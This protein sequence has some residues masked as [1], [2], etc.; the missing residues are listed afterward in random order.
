MPTKFHP[1]THLHPAVPAMRI[2]LIVFVLIIGQALA[3]APGVLAVDPDSPYNPLGIKADS[4]NA[5]APLQALPDNSQPEAGTMLQDHFG[6]ALGLQAAWG[7]GSYRSFN[8]STFAPTLNTGTADWIEADWY[9]NWSTDDFDYT[10]IRGSYPSGGEWYDVE[11]IYFDNDATNLY[12]A[13]V[14]SMPHLRDWGSGQVGVG[15]FERRGSINAWIRPGDVSLNLALG[16]PRQERNSTTWNY[17]LGVDIAHD[18][19]NTL[20]NAVGMRDND[21]GAS[22]YRTV[23][24]LGG[25]DVEN[26]ATS[27][28]YTSGPGYNVTAYWEHTNFDPFYTGRPAPTYVGETTVAYYE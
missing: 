12:V 28:W 24:D 3:G 16:T 6:V 1:R 11:A 15:I 19:R 13:I 25:S 8:P 22:L 20:G 26:P 2:L 10:T 14:T 5:T 9:G 27:D 17:N 18:N 7:G 23:Y 4:D 21:L